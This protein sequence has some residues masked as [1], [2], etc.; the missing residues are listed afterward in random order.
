MAP[1]QY[2]SF[3]FLMDPAE[4][5]NLETETSLLLIEEL[6]ARGHKIYWF[7]V[8]D[9]SLRGDELFAAA[10]Q[11]CCVS[12]LE[13]GPTFDLDLN[14]LDALLPRTDP[15]FDSTYL[16]VTYLL[17]FLAPH[18]TQFNSA[19]A[20]R[21]LNE[22]LLPLLWPDLAPATLTTMNLDALMSFLDEHQDIVIK[23][24]DDCSGRGIKRLKK[25]DEPQAAELA[26]LFEGPNGKQRF[27]MA[28]E[29]LPAVSQ[30]DK[31]VYL[32]NGKPVGAVNRTPKQGSFLA[33]IHQGAL[34]TPTKLT[35]QEASAIRTMAPTLTEA[36]IFLAGLDFIGGKVTEINITSPSA[37]R[38]INQVMGAEVHKEIVTAMIEHIQHR[39]TETEV[40]AIA[41]D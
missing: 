23:P 17:D 22:K 1:Y 4:T 30:G 25:S 8:A 11:V 12:P 31:R 24:L 40:Q 2:F 3:G 33:N 10:R 5:L 36:G 38:Q 16:H 27:I 21:N 34:C 6:L 13:F 20:L 41:A 37:I 28:Q 32:V 26:E 35:D 7:E 18:V 19:Y 15:P 14:R 9:L 29:F 39:R